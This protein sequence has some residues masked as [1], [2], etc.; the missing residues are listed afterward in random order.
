MTWRLYF[1]AWRQ[2]IKW[3]AL[4]HFTWNVYARITG[5]TRCRVKTV[6]KRAIEGEGKNSKWVTWYP[7][8]LF[9]WNWICVI[10]H[11]SRVEV[12]R[13]LPSLSPLWQQY[14]SLP[15]KKSLWIYGSQCVAGA[16]YNWDLGAVFLVKCEQKL[17]IRLF[18]FLFVKS[19]SFF[20][21]L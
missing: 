16:K 12:Q 1:D 18:S 5:D 10:H 13:T 8:H 6:S 14:T 9:D 11:E 15:W 7:H 21:S 3:Y 19:C 17:S 20:S 4:F 2:P